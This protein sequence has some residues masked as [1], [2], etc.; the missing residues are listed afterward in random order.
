MTRGGVVTTMRM[1]VTGVFIALVT[2]IELNDRVSFQT[3]LAKK[4]IRPHNDVGTAQVMWT[5]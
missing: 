3:D 4:M 5:T 1:A 2:A